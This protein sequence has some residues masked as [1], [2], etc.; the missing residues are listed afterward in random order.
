MLA[1]TFLEI[2]QTCHGELIPTIGICLCRNLWYAT[3]FI[4]HCLY[5]VH[6]A[7]SY[8]TDPFSQDINWT[9]FIKD[10]FYLLE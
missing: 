5:L 9:P 8:I 2:L 7:K 1:R 10:R 3:T 4:Y 6:V